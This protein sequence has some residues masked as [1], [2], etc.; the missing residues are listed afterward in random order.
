MTVFAPEV[1]EVKVQLVEGSVATQL[2][3]PSLTVTVPLGVP[4]PGEVTVKLNATR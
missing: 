4:A 3:A 2:A 1:V